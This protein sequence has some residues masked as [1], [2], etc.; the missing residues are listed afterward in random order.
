MGGGQRVAALF[1]RSPIRD[2][3]RGED[4]DHRN[5]QEMACLNAETERS[6][7]ESVRNRTGQPCGVAVD[8]PRAE[9]A[10][11]RTLREALERKRGASA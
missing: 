8:E 4:E 2:A 1:V 11:L 5:K 7:A 3:R 6:N 10:D 9:V